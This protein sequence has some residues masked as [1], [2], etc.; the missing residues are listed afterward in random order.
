M[1]LLFQEL[2]KELGRGVL[3]RA[4]CLEMAR[5]LNI[6]EGSFN[7]ALVYFFFFFFFKATR[8]LS[9]KKK[10]FENSHIVELDA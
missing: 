9:R 7:A 3:S 4:E 10:L 2:A 1:E 6:K 5:L 8:T